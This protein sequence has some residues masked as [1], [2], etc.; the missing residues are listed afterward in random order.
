MR[1]ITSST[2]LLAWRR[3]LSAFSYRN[4]AD[5]FAAEAAMLAVLG[6]EVAKA[7]LLDIGIGTGRTTGHLA[8]RCS[9]YVGVDYADGMVER[10]RH[11]FPGQ[12][13]RVMDARDLSAFPD[14]AFDLVVFSYNGLDYVGPD[15]RSKVLDEVRRVSRPGGAFMFSAH[16]LGASIPKAADLANLPV[17]LNPFRMAN[18]VVK[19]LRGIRNSRR[20]SA[21]ERHETGY[22]LLNDPAQQYQLLTYYISPAAQRRQ[23]ETSGFCQVR[24]F[25]Q[26][27]RELDLTP[28]GSAPPAADFMVHYLARRS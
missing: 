2:N 23:L 17:I 25:A 3:Q 27:G 11:R 8:G 9:S 7:R 22:A 13:L 1:D 19:Y 12:D 6:D 24:A 4:A 5:L 16:R 21:H 28:G 10:A 26:S 18:A 20:L 15:D 14:G